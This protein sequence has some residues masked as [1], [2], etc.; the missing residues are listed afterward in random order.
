MRR[1]WEV[2]G[3]DCGKIPRAAGIPWGND[4]GDEMV[5]T[6][7]S[8]HYQKTPFLRRIR[9]GHRAAGWKA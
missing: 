6:V 2:G 4:A 8:G 5:E 9:C 3:N 7:T 1:I